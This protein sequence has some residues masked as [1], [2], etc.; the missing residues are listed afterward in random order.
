MK[1]LDQ[2]NEQE[3]LALAISLEEEDEHFYSDLSAA[4]RPDFSASATMFDE[5]GKEESNHRHRLID[6]YRKK[7][8]E[9][10]PF[11]RRQDVRGFIQRKSI[12]LY[13]PINLEKI[14]K[15]IGA[16]EAETMQFYKKAADRMQDASIRQLLDD[17]AQAERGHIQLAEDLEHKN[18]ND[19]VKAQELESQRRLFLLQIVQPG[20]AG[21]M[22]GSVSTLAPLFAAAFATHN[23][24]TTFVVGLAAS[25]GAGI[26]M[27]FA[28]ALS[29]DGALTGRGHPLLR[30]SI[31]GLMTALGG[32]G[33]TLPFLI[34]NFMVAL[35]I[36]IT[37][38]LI[39]L[40]AI[41]W[42]RHRYMDTPTL[43]ALVQVLLGGLLV[44]LSGIII[45]SS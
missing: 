43:Y 10:I 3:I 11:I 22:D 21:L 30:G 5:M 16:M 12:W 36:S 17:L 18:I 24:W 40:L 1:D 15:Q 23:S 32:I 26:S 45:G 28:E 20:L 31:C 9:H 41:S 38:V 29:D 44:F 39:E 14:R 35:L 6:L 25:V 8:G 7:F 19:N 34:P 37:V 2:L 4:I 42:V 13:Q 33:H 27:G